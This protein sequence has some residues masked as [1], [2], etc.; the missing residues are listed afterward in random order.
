MRL[1]QKNCSTVVD[2]G[3]DGWLKYEIMCGYIPVHHVFSLDLKTSADEDQTTKTKG[4]LQGS[5]SRTKNNIP[6]VAAE[7]P[8]IE[9][10][11]YS[12]NT[13]TLMSLYD[14][15][16]APSPDVKTENSR[17]AL[18]YQLLFKIINGF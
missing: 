3:V 13:G 2:C 6:S 16:N 10:P 11:I 1:S 4:L 14:V 15:W 12:N 5:I 18:K 9:D 17:I 8:T 7:M